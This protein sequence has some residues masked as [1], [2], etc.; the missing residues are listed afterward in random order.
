M[1][2]VTQAAAYELGENA[3]GAH[4]HEM[5]HA[6]VIHRFDHPAET[7]GRSQLIGQ[8]SARCFRRLGVY[9][10]G[11]VGVDVDVPSTPLHRREVA[12]E[13]LAAVGDD[14]GVEGRG[15]GKTNRGQT[16]TLELLLDDVDRLGG[17][18]EH[19]FTRR[20]V[21]RDHHIGIVSDQASDSLRVRRYGEHGAR[22]TPSRLCHQLTA[23]ARG[24]EKAGRL[25]APGSRQRC[26]F[27]ETVTGHRVGTH[28]QLPKQAQV[29]EA[30]RC[31]GRLRRRHIGETLLLVRPLRIRERGRRKDHT[32]ERV[33]GELFHVGRS[34]PNLTDR[35]EGHGSRGTHTHVLTSLSGKDESELADRRRPEPER[36]VSVGK[37]PECPIGDRVR[38]PSRLARKL[39]DVRRDE[40]NPCFGARVEAQC[41]VMRNKGERVA[42]F[43][44]GLH[45][46]ERG[47][48]LT[49]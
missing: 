7:N 47:T 40:C 32:M 5:G 37:I 48:Q 21:I 8:Q 14:A 36:D 38:G 23:L 30:H 35:V 41:A 22:L 43:D 11:S 15:H 31:D 1:R 13:R 27:T 18:S 34:V 26:Q 19:D 17:T 20:V 42:F 49:R 39:V 3:T 6:R 28:S 29:A 44:T 25:D 45:R 10:G 33:I 9:V 46:V 24:R 16:L 12:V 2:T 4:L